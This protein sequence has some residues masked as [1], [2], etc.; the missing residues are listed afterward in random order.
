MKKIYLIP[1]F[2]G[3]A[4]SAF[5]GGK[6]DFA[7]QAVLDSY[8]AGTLDK[9]V[10]K[11]VFMAPI[12]RGGEATVKVLVETDGSIPADMPYEYFQ[13]SSNF[14]TVDIPVDQLEQFS[15]NAEVV[16]MSFGKIASTMMD[17]ARTVDNGDVDRV[18]AGSNLGDRIGQRRPYKGTGVIAAIYDTGFDPAHINWFTA[19]GSENRLKYYLRTTS[20]YQE[21]Y[22]DNAP[23]ALTDDAG[24]SHGTHVAGIMAGAY[25]G[26]GTYYDSK[27]VMQTTIPYYGVAPEAEIAIGAGSL[28]TSAIV[29]GTRRL[30]NYA[31]SQ[32]K[33]IAINLSL[34]NNIGAHDGTTADVRALD[35]IADETGAIIVVAAGND[36][37]IACHAG[38]TFSSTDKKLT[39]LF[40]RNRATKPVDVWSSTADAFNVSIV[41]VDATTGEIMAKVS[42]KNS[43]TV[44]VGA[45]GSDDEAFIKA[46]FTGSAT[47]RAGLNAINRRYQVYVSPNNLAA[48]SANDGKYLLGLMIEGGEDVRVDVYGN[49]DAYFASSMLPG[50]D[51]PDMNGS[52]SDLACGMRTIVVGSYN[53]RNEWYTHLGV[54]PISYTSGAALGAISEFSSWGDLIDGR[55]M[56]HITA[57]GMAIL[58]SFS[59]PYVAAGNSGIYDLVATATTNGTTYYWG[60]MQGTS[61]ACPFVTG[62]MA[63]WLEADPNLTV[64]TARDIL[65]STAS[66]D[67]IYTLDTRWGAGKIK[68]HPGIREVKKRATSGIGNIAVAGDDNFDIAVSGG[69][70]EVFASGASTVAV[71]LYTVGGALAASVSSDGDTA[72][73]STDGLA[74]GV[75]VLRASADG[76]RTATRKIVL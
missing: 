66:T 1:I 37:D 4:P 11:A 34:G 28:A 14:I 50:I 60:S 40:N 15:E 23:G 56:P 22:G 72:Q 75:Y 9:A 27:G 26:A 55:K 53:T 48:T 10:E 41:A 38:K 74:K 64:D 54:G 29:E 62:V 8:R 57:P 13:V 20:G 73:L 44:N 31:R 71:Q 58:S 16:T 3:L 76:S 49:A 68:A 25:N 18:H 39:V 36:G 12:S 47:L 17:N 42:S 46:N 70:C 21:Y 52:I 69:V 65:A 32:G 61:M 6:I 5:A 63:L 19:D 24:E 45:G 2:L 59:S 33:P 7:S 35:Q 43:A 30:A 51:I 67:G